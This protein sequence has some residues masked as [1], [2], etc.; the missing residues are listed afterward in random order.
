[1]L[2]LTARGTRVNTVGRGTVEAVVA[3]TLEGV[4]GRDRRAT[5]RVLARLA[6]HLRQEGDRRH[7]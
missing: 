3:G 4:S 5:R 1:V 2:R 7:A 6:T